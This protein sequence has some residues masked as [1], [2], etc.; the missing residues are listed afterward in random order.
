MIPMPGEYKDWSEMF[1]PLMRVEIV[2][3]GTMPDGQT[4]EIIIP[5]MEI[6]DSENAA[7]RFREEN[8]E[9]LSDDFK[10]VRILPTGRYHASLFLE[11]TLLKQ[12]ADG[13][14]FKII[15]SEEPGVVKKD[16]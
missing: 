6:Q 11:G 13:N 5:Q 8:E 16:A 9:T 15:T 1:L 4:V 2:V 3:K 10:S 7:F 12:E 14:L